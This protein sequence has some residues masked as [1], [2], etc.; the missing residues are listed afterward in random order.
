MAISVVQNTTG[1]GSAGTITTSAFA[2][3]TT[4]GNSIVVFT[5]GTTTHTYSSV[6]DSAGNT[7]RQVDNNEVTGFGISG[8]YVAQAWICTNIT[9]GSSVTVSAFRFA[10]AS[11][12]AAI[13]ATE[14]SGVALYSAQEANGHISLTTSSTNNGGTVSTG[15]PKCLIVGGFGNSVFGSFSG[16]HWT[17]GSGYSNLIGNYNTAAAS[18]DVCMESKQVSSA[19]IYTPTANTTDTSSYS[20]GAITVALGGSSS[21]PAVVQGTTGTVNSG[22]TCTTAAFASSTTTGNTVVVFIAVNGSPSTVTDSAGNTYTRVITHA[23]TTVMGFAGTFF[24]YVCNNITGGS[25]VTITQSG[26]S[27]AVMTAQEFSGVVTTQV[28][29]GYTGGNHTALASGAN[30]LSAIT[31]LNANDLLLTSLMESQTTPP[32]ISADTGW[33]NS[34]EALQVSVL[35]FT[36][37]QLA[38]LSPTDVSGTLAQ[39]LIAG[40]PQPSAALTTTNAHD[41]IVSCFLDYS[42]NISSQIWSAGSGSNFNGTFGGASSHIAIGMQSTSV[43]STGTYTPNMTSSLHDSTGY[44]SMAIALIATSPTHVQDTTGQTAVSGNITSSAFGSNTTTGN[45]IIVFVGSTSNYATAVTDSAG[46]V[47]TRINLNNKAGTV[48][49]LTAWVCTNITGGTTPTITATIPSTFA[50]STIIAQ[51]WSGINTSTIAPYYPTVVSSAAG[52]NPYGSIT[53]A[54]QAGAVGPATPKRTATQTRTS[55]QVRVA[56]VTRSATQ[57][58]TAIS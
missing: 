8:L 4:T 21:S 24:A 19:G 23:A 1:A 15:N 10:S 47:Y 16:Q 33:T 58:R 51:E 28:I 6:T 13:T 41:L 37:S 7:Y 53:M 36:E 45:C 35:T 3:S 20:Y 11:G 25:S 34:V 26:G 52:S 17:A 27:N 12:N 2:S 32:S 56:T 49:C 55:T 14:V 30:P 54:L 42:T 38:P 29:E 39:T 9:G 44:G 48:G 5:N 57:V 50:G 46:N 31:T 18:Y 40:N 43:S 22:T